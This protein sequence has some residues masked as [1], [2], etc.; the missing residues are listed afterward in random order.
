MAG[1]MITGRRIEKS[2]SEQERRKASMLYLHGYLG[3]AQATIHKA[4]FQRTI[5]TFQKRTGIWSVE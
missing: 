2:I 1:L 3:N 4:T 5:L